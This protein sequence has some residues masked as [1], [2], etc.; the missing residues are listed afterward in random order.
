M[1]LERI[2]RTPQQPGSDLAVGCFCSSQSDSGPYGARDEAGQSKIR[3]RTTRKYQDVE[4][5]CG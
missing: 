1:S 4:L 3:K 2:E 5:N